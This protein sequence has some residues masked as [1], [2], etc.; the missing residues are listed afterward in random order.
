MRTQMT[1]L[2]TI[3]AVICIAAMSVSSLTGAY[4][5]QTSE[6]EI[7]INAEP[8]YGHDENAKF[9]EYRYPRER[10]IGVGTKIHLV[11]PRGENSNMILDAYANSHS[12][13]GGELSGVS[14][15]SSSWRLSF[16]RIGH[17]YVLNAKS[18]HGGTNTNALVVDDNVQ[19]T[20]QQNGYQVY[21]QRPDTMIERLQPLIDA[22]S[23]VDVRSTRDI[24]GYNYEKISKH[25]TYGFDVTHEIRR[26]SKPVNMAF[27]FANTV[28]YAEPI[29]Y[30][31][32]NFTLTDELVGAPYHMKW[33]LKHSIFNNE[34]QTAT[35]ENPFRID[36]SAH[37]SAYSFGQDT[38][39]ATG[40][41][42]LPPSNFASQA[43]MIFSKPLTEHSHIAVDASYGVM[44]QR[45]K[46][47]PHALNSA[48]DTVG[49]FLPGGVLYGA[50]EADAQVTNMLADVHYSSK[51]GD[52]G[53]LGVAYKFDDHKNKT[54]RLN[55]MNKV[56]IDAAIGTNN[57]PLTLVSVTTK[58]FEVEYEYEA[59]HKTTYSLTGEYVRESFTQG[60][61]SKIKERVYKLGVNS[62]E[63]KN[64][65][66]RA[67]IEREEKRADYPNY[68]PPDKSYL[69]TAYT[70]DLPWSRKYYAATR[71][72]HKVV[73]MASYTPTD[74]TALSFDYN[75]TDDDYYQSI[76]GLQKERRHSGTAEIDHELT[77][78]ISWN[79]SV[80]FEKIW[81]FMKS[82][83]WTSA[84]TSDPYSATGANID[85]PSNWTLEL[86]E[87]DRTLEM[88]MQ[89]ALVPDKWIVS[90]TGDYVR[91]KG[92]GDFASPIGSVTTDANAYEP[93]DLAKVDNSKRKTLDVN[94]KYMD[95]AG[96][97]TW[98]LGYMAERFILED[99]FYFD[100]YRTAPIKNSGQWYGML[101]LDSISRDYKVR[102]VYAS[103]NFSY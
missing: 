8:I 97:S 38:G 85:D 93:V 49:S 66:I 60:S 16:K 54:T 30:G 47:V 48:L 20:L 45:E 77:D 35:V 1:K 52:K 71:N 94:L 56:H 13:I 9:N 32:T 81:S 90:L 24:M 39:T 76:F 92:T 34:Y 15:G 27:G 4:A 29:R 95:E 50:W 74:N 80:T 5:F 63:F 19:R 17:I 75:F 58:L 2:M 31:T 36:D 23:T 46:I 70:D 78:R 25:H 98:K 103:A 72:R 53:H 96:K 7:E 18:L 100:G 73:T 101:N 83:Q 6:K 62:R 10:E 89:V 44:R 40:R 43:T 21:A 67:D 28:E 11:S 61:A 37:P 84:S 3:A 26:G 42:A 33:E 22:A 91:I 65:I 79:G 64:L 12:D 51:L 86:D 88:G 69:A 59:T 68:A 87:L 57:T 55:F 82:R 14:Q 102:T 99:P 41:A